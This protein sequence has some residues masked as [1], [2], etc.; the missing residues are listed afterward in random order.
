MTVK[1]FKDFLRLGAVAGNDLAA[2]FL[3][4]ENVADVASS[5]SHD[6]TSQVLMCKMIAES[7]A[8]TADTAS[9]CDDTS[10]TTASFSA[11]A[12]SCAEECTECAWSTIHSASQGGNT[13]DSAVE[14]VLQVEEPVQEVDVPDNRASFACT[15]RLLG[16]APLG[17]GGFGQVWRCSAYGDASPSAEK[18]VKRIKTGAL[19]AAGRQH[20]YDEVAIQCKLRHPHIVALHGVFCD[21]KGKPTELV[22]LVLEFCLGGDILRHVSAARQISG[23]GL[24]ESDAAV[25]L[26]QV[27]LAL[28]FLHGLRIVHRD[29]RCENVLLTQRDLPL[30]KTTCKLC[31]FGLAATLPE[32]SSLRDYVGAPSSTAPE[33][34]TG[35]P[36]AMPVDLWS[37]GVMLYILLVASSPFPGR[38]QREIADKVRRGIFSLDTQPWSGISDDAKDLVRRLLQLDAT[39]RLDAASAL[40]DIWITR[41]TMPVISEEQVHARSEPCYEAF[42]WSECVESSALPSPVSLKPVEHL[43][44]EHSRNNYSRHSPNAARKEVEKEQLIERKSETITCMQC[45]HGLLE[46]KTWLL[47]RCPLSQM[48][49]WEN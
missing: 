39:F 38:N 44:L 3:L 15:H 41:Y 7:C 29:I 17:S 40:Q 31:D 6:L 4:Y 21:F 9:V 37:T 43:T 5:A 27:L 46:R 25:A 8:S 22:S 1:R 10:S 13:D 2:Q 35:K 36:Y 45:L 16:D 26:Q 28:E 11:I 34:V 12:E 49:T 14:N 19:C 23:K 30:R 33:V 18:A 24:A 47:E 32:G 42:S 20:V 48:L